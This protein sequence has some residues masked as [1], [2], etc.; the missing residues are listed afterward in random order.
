MKADSTPQ[1]TPGKPS[2]SSKKP[3]RPRPDFPLSIHK[4]T[5]YW[6]K[7]VKGHVTYFGK[8]ADDPK[9]VAAEEEWA[10]VKDDLYAGREPREKN[11]GMTLEEL[12]FRFLAHHEEKRDNGELSP[13]TYHGYFST[14]ETVAKTLGRT[15]AVADLVPDDFRKLRTKLAKTRKAVALKNEMVRVRSIFKFA[16]DEGLIIA[17]VKFGK[18]FATPRK[19]TIDKQRE[20][21]RMEHGYRMFEADELR[22]ILATCSQP[23]KAMVLLA[24]NCGFGQS[25]CSSL[26]TKAV[27]LDSGWVDFP[28]VKNSRPRRVPLWPETVAAIREWLP[29]RPKARDTADAGLLFLTCRGSRWVK[30]NATGSPADALG[31]EFS[32]VLRKLGM[33]RRGVSFYALRHGFETIAGET[34]DQFSVDSIMGHSDCSMASAYRER[35]DDH[36][37]QAVVEH[38]RDWLFAESLDDEPRVSKSEPSQGSQ[39]QSLHVACSR[40]E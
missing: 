32:K 14:A 26:P 30:L 5:G 7:K 10:R 34:T 19:E 27:N 28:R 13:R 4:G 17:P 36:R 12:C 29:L 38:V 33:K 11:D 3:G 39:R 35:I 40:V 6:C 24:A 1:P 2:R 20:A 23:L 18:G 8:V 21:H 15:R 25:D 22:T 16:F 9:G 31:G 37:L